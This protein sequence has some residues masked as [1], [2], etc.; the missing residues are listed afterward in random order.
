MQPYGLGFAVGPRSSDVFAEFAVKQTLVAAVLTVVT[1]V[2]SAAAA[3]AGLFETEAVVS[4]APGSTAPSPSPPG[5]TLQT[6][7]GR[8]ETSRTYTPARGSLEQTALLEAL[9]PQVERDLGTAVILQVTELM[10][11]EGWAFSVLQPVRPDGRPI[12]LDTTPLAQEAGGTEFIDGLRT[13]VLWRRR[14]D[15]WAVEAYGI[16]ATDVWYEDYCRIVPH[17]LILICQP[18]ER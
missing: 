14:S 13:E 10:I 2:A 5:E 8:A 18:L 17:G 7:H 15:G 16:G 1:A 4:G 3:S 12:N 9:R 6:Q 11:K